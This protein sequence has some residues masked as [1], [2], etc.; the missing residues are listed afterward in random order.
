MSN[1]LVK[2]SIL[3]NSRRR[4]SILNSLTQIALILK[5]VGSKKKTLTLNK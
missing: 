5:R 3:G 1:G 2:I 4:G